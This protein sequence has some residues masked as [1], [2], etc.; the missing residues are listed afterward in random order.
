MKAAI[1]A[2]VAQFVGW[3][4]WK[5]WN[6]ARTREIQRRVR[7]GTDIKQAEID[8]S[9]EQRKIRGNEARSVLENRHLREA[10]KAV[11]DAVEAEALSCSRDDRE[12]AHRIVI[13]KQLAVMFERELVRKIEDGY[14]AEVELSELEARRRPRVFR[15]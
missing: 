10:L 11:Y 5:I 1:L 8:L 2:K 9:A 3:A 12:K 7:R 4:L 13:T 15:R 14:V 6:H